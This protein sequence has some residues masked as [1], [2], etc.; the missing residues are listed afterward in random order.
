MRLREFC[1]ANF[2]EGLSGMQRSEV[3]IAVM[4]SDQREYEILV[5]RSRREKI[6]VVSPQLYYFG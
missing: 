2:P 1:E 5:Q 6:Q 4:L 3:L